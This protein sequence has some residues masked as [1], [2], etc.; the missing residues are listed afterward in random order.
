MKKY[1]IGQKVKIVEASLRQP[2]ETINKIGII[3]KYLEVCKGYE[4]HFISEEFI[5]KTGWVYS[6]REIISA[7]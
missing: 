1:K 3:V 4:V 5:D 7:E 6:E 2:K